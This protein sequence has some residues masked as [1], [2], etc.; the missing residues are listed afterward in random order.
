MS[1]NENDD[2]E[3]RIRALSP[4]QLLQI[5]QKL[6]EDPNLTEE[7]RKEFREI[8]LLL[9]EELAQRGRKAKQ[10]IDEKGEHL[11]RLITELEEQPDL[12]DEQRGMLSQLSAGLAGALLSSWLP[13]DLSRKVLMFLFV[14]L[15]VIGMVQWSLWFGLL[16]I[17]GAFFSPRI[18]GECILVIGFIREKLGN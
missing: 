18:L 2:L 7:Q 10:L 9:V 11:L 8:A 13:R 5:V 1:E 15:G 4:D 17:L 14:A 6:R 12:T 3:D 16:I